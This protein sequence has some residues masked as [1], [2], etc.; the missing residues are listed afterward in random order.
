MSTTEIEYDQLRRW[1]AEVLP[2]PGHREFIEARIRKAHEGLEGVRFVQEIAFEVVASLP[3][4]Y[5]ARNPEET[6]WPEQPPS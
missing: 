5:E 6:A 1:L 2:N 3:D 4:A